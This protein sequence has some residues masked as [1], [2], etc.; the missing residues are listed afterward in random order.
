M[1]RPRA[2]HRALARLTGAPRGR[3]WPGGFTDR[4]TH[5]VPGPAAVL[6]LMRERGTRPVGATG[7]RVPV[8]EE[9]V[10]RVGAGQAAV[11]WI[12]HATC[13][14]QLGGRAVLTDPV[15]AD[16]IPGTPRRYTPPGVSWESLPPI[17]AVVISHNHF[18]HLDEPTVRR[19][20]RDTPVL[21]PAGLA[22]WFQTRGFRRVVELDWWES[23]VVGGVRFDFTPAHHWSRRGLFDTC[24]SLWGGWL[25][26]SEE[27]PTH[28]VFFAGDSAYGPAFAEIGARFPDID[29]A[30]LPVGAFRPRWFMKPLHMDPAEAVRACGDLGAER[31][32]TIHWGT[33][34]LSAEPV[35]APVELARKA[36]AESGR[37]ADALWDLAV[38][39]SRQFGTTDRS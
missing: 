11:T 23:T 4:L 34:A 5:P 36:W 35:L 15:F 2:V 17:D 27:T 3:D 16:K 14:V 21:V 28:R 8:V 32:V 12:G 9:A 37:P 1:Y 10:P 26:T 39:Q 38:G 6:R 29:V 33:F 7:G 13:L 30:L 22:W 19:L 20:P 25:M 24:Q 18:D 31:M